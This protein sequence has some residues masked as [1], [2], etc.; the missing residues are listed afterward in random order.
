MGSTHY[1]RVFS[2]QSLPGIHVSKRS[3]AEASGHQPVMLCNKARPLTGLPYL[4][5]ATRSS[6]KRPRAGIDSQH[7][8]PASTKQGS[9]SWEY[10]RT[11]TRRLP[12]RPPSIVD[13]EV[14]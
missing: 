11:P 5:A 7:Q 9:G 8:Q 14:A 4:A 12:A 13:N 3:H 1:R 6:S 10:R 2:R